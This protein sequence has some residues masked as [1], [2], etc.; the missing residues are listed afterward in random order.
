MISPIYLD[1]RIMQ[2]P[3]LAAQALKVA[4]DPLKKYQQIN[5]SKV[6]T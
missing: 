1:N 4:V 6:L 5:N 2:P 3:Y